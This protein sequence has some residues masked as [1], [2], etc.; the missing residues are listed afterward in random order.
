MATI[1]PSNLAAG[2]ERLR[3]ALDPSLAEAR[4]EY[5]AAESERKLDRHLKRKYPG[6][7]G[8]LQC[9]GCK[10]IKP[11]GQHVCGNCGY[12]DGAGYQSVPA[13]TSYLERWR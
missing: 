8:G 12:L 10:R 3:L 2:I 13:T 7:G 9:A 5:L 1:A 4:A 6:S 11:L